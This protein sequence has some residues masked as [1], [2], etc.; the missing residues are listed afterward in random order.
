MD[1]TVRF[2]RVKEAAAVHQILM[3]AFA[4][5]EGKIKPPFKVFKATPAGIAAG[6]RNRRHRYAIAVVDKVPVGTMR[7]TPK[8][9]PRIGDY[10]LLS[11]LAV[12]PEYQGSHIAK[13]LIS[14]MHEKAVRHDVPELRGHV[15][16]ALPKLIRFYQRCGY[17]V[18]GYISTPGFPKYVAV[19]GRRLG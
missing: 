18:L 19:V 2:A 13:R 9:C 11:R 8:H 3:D 17:R 7:L 1:L 14:W 15:R 5:Y 16:T 12:A 10:W 6:I 4:P